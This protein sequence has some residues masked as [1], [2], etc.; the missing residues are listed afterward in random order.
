[1][2]VHR[3]QVDRT[4]WKRGPSFPSG[5]Y[6]VMAAR[7]ESLL[8]EHQASCRA[9][10]REE[11]IKEPFS[12]LGQAAQLPAPGPQQ[13]IHPDLIQFLPAKP[14][15]FSHRPTAGLQPQSL[16]GEFRLVFSLRVSS[17]RSGS[18]SASESPRVLGQSAHR[19]GLQT[20]CTVGRSVNIA[21]R[22]SKNYTSYRRMDVGR[23]PGREIITGNN[24]ERNAQQNGSSVSQVERWLRWRDGRPFQS[25]PPS[26]VEQPRRAPLGGETPSCPPR[27]GGGRARS[28]RS[29]TVAKQRTRVSLSP[30]HPTEWRATTPSIYDSRSEET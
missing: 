20:V 21:V 18:S 26:E 1:M 23:G 30:A 27:R 16:L 11:N 10:M 8:A 29:W 28:G 4:K 12:V 22:R 5:P 25:P 15:I 9:L 13:T 3:V 7:L 17:V 24:Q 6:H 19:S 2:G 14:S